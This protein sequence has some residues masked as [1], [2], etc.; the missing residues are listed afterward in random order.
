MLP[1]IAAAT[2]AR[3][4]LDL[5]TNVMLMLCSAPCQAMAASA[6]DGPLD[7]AACD[8]VG[9]N[10]RTTLDIVELFVRALAGIGPVQVAITVASGDAQV[11]AMATIPKSLRRTIEVGVLWTRRARQRRPRTHAP[12]H[13]TPPCITSY[14]PESVM[15]PSSASVF[16]VPLAA[17]HPLTH[18]VLATPWN[19]GD[20]MAGG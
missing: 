15:S 13:L 16:N 10:N 7:A 4:L 2:C 11:N 3:R 14:S 5:R 20:E 8:P 19:E 12:P 6:A 1:T 9:H 18:P 17:T